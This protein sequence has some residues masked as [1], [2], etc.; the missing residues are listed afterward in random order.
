MT[1]KEQ[2]KV[3]II[4]SWYPPKGGYFFREHAVALAA[5]GLKVNVLAGLHTSLRTLTPANLFKAC[6]TTT[7]SFEG[8]AEHT[9]K[10]W[11]IPFSD[12][13]NFHGWVS[14]MLRFYK[15]YQQ[16][17]GPPHV[18]LAH[19]SIWAGLVAAFIREK[20]DIP[21][22]I[23]EHRS[24]FIYNTAEA[25]KMFKPWFFSYL[26]LA[27][28]GAAR[29]I[30]VSD[31]LQP[32][33]KQI[34]P[35]AENNLLSIPNM[36]DTEFFY[37]AKRPA[38]NKPFVFFSLANLIPLKGMDTLIEA[39]AL[40]Q[41]EEPDTFRLIIG[42]HGPER[43]RL[44]KLANQR[45]LKGVVG[46]TGRL[47]R[48]EIR[49]HMQ[50]AHAFALASHFEAFGVVYIEAMACGKPVIASRAGGPESFI[51]ES[52]GILV[53]AGNPQKFAQA[54]KKMKENFKQFDQDGIRSYAVKNFGKESVAQQYIKIFNEIVT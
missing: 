29:V 34:A 23:T 6:Q 4:P 12:K 17:H 15:N 33:I 37:P 45:A 5:A 49:Q 18:I 10:Y 1:A 28:D 48:E 24:R 31:A 41:D 7:N 20:Y 2:I 14:M 27:F 19:S 50:K 21:Y 16:K 39:M 25:K 11:I 36:V 22:I 32:F 42:G 52:E 51:R 8:I 40:L 13:P 47:S 46:F 43:E 38:I 26:E 35:G 54:M 53:Q 30:T 9:K 3:L 44:E